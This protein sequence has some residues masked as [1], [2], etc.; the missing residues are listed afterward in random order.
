M[1]TVFLALL[2]GILL[3]IFTGITPGIHTN[4]VA[5]IILSSLFL[6]NQQ[7][8]ILI[9][10]IVSL[11]ITHTFLDSIP[12]IYLGAPDS[13]QVL[14]ILPGHKYFLQG[15][16]YEAF[17]LTLI[18][19][20]AAVIISIILFLPL[21]Y[22]IKN[23]YSL[24]YSYI[25]YILILS[26]LILMLKEKHKFMTLII[27]F[28]AGILGISVLSLNLNQPLLPLFS[29]LFAIPSLILSLS[30]KTELKSQIITFPV[31]KI[32][33][34]FS[35]FSLALFSS[36]LSGTLPGLGPAQAASLV[37]SIKKI[38][39]EYYLILIGSLNTFIMFI[40]FLTLYAIDKARNGSV[41]AIS[42]L[43]ENFSFN[44]LILA[45]AVS[46]IAA[47]IATIL[48]MK[49]AKKFS[50]IISK[51]NYKK[52]SMFIIL[53]ITALTIYLAG[54]T[55]LLILITSA[56]LGLFVNLKGI[57]RSHLMS[58][59]IIPVIFYYLL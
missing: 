23:Y 45:L 30:Q 52:L 12:S 15:K 6:R 16:A 24:I 28:L 20:L 11:A 3:G 51:I 4:L 46:L 49:I 21:I 50:V 27:I 42:Q 10:F 33:E 59:L 22:L 55:G 2:L 14:S 38:K 9:T 25:P 8:E 19:S 36:I 37:E 56:F 26:I 53:F 57:S 1:I 29:G 47:G 58:S 18:G 34:L 39:T 17:T 41:I 43:V 40:S 54:F 5:T 44:Y 32:K 48:A 35:T 13:D 31:L 7:P